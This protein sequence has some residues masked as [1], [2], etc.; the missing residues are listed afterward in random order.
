M[1][2]KKILKKDFTSDRQTGIWFLSFNFLFFSFFWFHLENLIFSLVFHYFF[3]Y[4]FLFL[5]LIWR[6]LSQ[7]GFTIHNPKRKI[8]KKKI[9]F[10]TI[11]KQNKS[12]LMIIMVSHSF[13]YC[14]R[15]CC[16]HFIKKKIIFLFFKKLSKGFLHTVTIDLHN[17]FWIFSFFLSLT[18]NNF[19]H[20][21]SFRFV[22][23]CMR[24]GYSHVECFWYLFWRQKRFHFSSQLF[25]CDGLAKV[26][27]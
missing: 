10:V 26:F 22:L 4:F 21:V 2:S 12:L 19:F 13:S 14:L 9:I 3:L 20:F 7:D 23:F 11:I 25:G 15:D 16:F 8:K 5:I 1:V 24:Y 6:Q 18:F 17:F 27:N